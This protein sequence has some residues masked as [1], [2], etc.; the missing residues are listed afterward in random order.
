MSTNGRPGASLFSFRDYLPNSNIYGADIDENILFECDRIKTC[1]ID[2]LDMNTFDNIKTKFGDIK[3]DLIIDDG[4]HSIGAN[5][6]TLLFAL[7]NINDNGWIVIEDINLNTI[8]NW[9]SVDFI[10]KSSNKFITYIIKS[11][12]N[13]Y[14]YVINKL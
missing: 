4:L 11:K 14:L 7:Y 2:Q 1:Y 3:Y 5:L 13:A 10:L 8:D 6:N 12:N 9:R